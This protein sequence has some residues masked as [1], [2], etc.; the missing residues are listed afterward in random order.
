MKCTD[1]AVTYRDGHNIVDAHHPRWPGKTPGKPAVHLPV[2]GH[3]AGQLPAD[4]DGHNR[5]EV[6]HPLRRRVVRRAESRGPA[7]TREGSV[8]VDGTVGFRTCR[9]GHHTLQARDSLRQQ[10]GLLGPV[11]E[12]ARPIAPPARHPAI[13][14]DGAGVRPPRSD[15]HRIGDSRNSDRQVTTP[16]V[17]LPEL[18]LEPRPPAGH[19]FPPREARR[20][21]SPHRG[22]RRC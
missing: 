21:A 12:L 22:R 5:R 3:G 16:A 13:A 19:G 15:R 20:R 17:A 10:P 4:R 14:V 11:A 18:S 7:P 2:D 1:T 9:N 6:S 8:D